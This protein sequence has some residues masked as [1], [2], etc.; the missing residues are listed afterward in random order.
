MGTSTCSPGDSV[1]LYLPNRSTTNAV[2]CGTILRGEEGRPGARL[3]RGA[4][5][6][7]RRQAAPAPHVD[8]MCAGPPLPGPHPCAVP[9]DRVCGRGSR[10]KWRAGVEQGCRWV[11]GARRERPQRL[12]L[13]PD[14]AGGRCLAQCRTVSPRQ[15]A[16]LL[17]G[18]PHCVC[19]DPPEPK[20]PALHCQTPGIAVLRDPGPRVTAKVRLPMPRMRHKRNPPPR[21]RGL[22]NLRPNRPSIFRSAAPRRHGQA[23]PQL[24]DPADRLRLVELGRSPC[25]AARPGPHP[26]QKQAPAG[27]LRLQMAAQVAWLV[28]LLLALA[29]PAAAKHHKYEV[30][31]ARGAAQRAGR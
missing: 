24:N 21:S 9:D 22:L 14:R 5:A 23:R 27:G 4:Q 15:A 25:P 2:C 28:A 1:R 17:G 18:A 7:A 10:G 13:A 19:G 6:V 11:N 31:G 12:L 30:R 3:S 16:Q 29:G 8:H 26:S 20:P